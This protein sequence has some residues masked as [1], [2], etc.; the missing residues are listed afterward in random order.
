MALTRGTLPAILLAIMKSIKVLSF[1]TAL[2]LVACDSLSR[3]IDSSTAFDPLRAPGN[4]NKAN[5]TGGSQFVAGQFVHATS[6]SAAFYKVR[7]KGEADADKL[8]KKGT[9]MKVI[10]S[11][12]SYVK[13]ELD[14]GEI[15]FVP[16]VMLEKPDEWVDV[17]SPNPGERQVYPPLPSEMAEPLPSLD[18]GGLP[19][20]GSIP[21]VID[22]DA[23]AD[24]TPVPPV[25]PSTGT[26]PAPKPDEKE[27]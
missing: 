13:V 16:S 15:G 7:P 8:L 27:N 24:K 9:S 19:P 18:P 2:G 5:Q 21:Q 11:S 26:F 14:S 4:L 12:G 17:S 10:S 20:E 22:P 25:T 6:D 1:L 23:P 3:P